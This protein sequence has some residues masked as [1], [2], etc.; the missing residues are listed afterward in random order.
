MKEPI[1][2]L[3]Q[4]LEDKYSKALQEVKIIIANLNGT[5]NLKTITDDNPAGNFEKYEKLK[6]IDLKDIKR[7]NE[8]DGTKEFHSW[9]DRF[10]DLLI[11]RNKDWNIVLDFLE[12]AANGPDKIN[13]DDF[14]Y[15]IGRKLGE[16]TA[17]DQWNLRD[18]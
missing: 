2:N 14:A 18:Q 13:H 15:E 3:R 4:E 16:A 17:W 7:T 1:A 9:F 6:P 11:N 5:P 10:R 12:E 8:F